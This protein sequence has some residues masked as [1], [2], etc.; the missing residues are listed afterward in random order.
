MIILL[1]LILGAMGSDVKF[2]M[3]ET[4]PGIF[5]ERQGKVVTERGKWKVITSLNLNEYYSSYQ[6]IQNGIKDLEII[7]SSRTHSTRKDSCDLVRREMEMQFDQIRNFNSLIYMESKRKRRFI[8]AAAT[9]VAAAA[10]AGI[11]GAKVYDWLFGETNQKVNQ[12][13]VLLNEQISVLETTEKLLKQTQEN[14]ENEIENLINQ[15]TQMQDQILT[16]S[17]ATEIIDKGL[18]TTTHLLLI[19]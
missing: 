4:K 6:T 10:A 5:F 17:K 18:W 9:V 8:G 19:M 1:G 15:T 16:M 2:M 12:L 14:F 7:C 13:E 3:T 11:V